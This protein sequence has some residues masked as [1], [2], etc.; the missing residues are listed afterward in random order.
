MKLRSPLNFVVSFVFAALA[1]AGCGAQT[2]LATQWSNPGYGAPPPFKKIVVG[3][4]GGESAVR[5]NFEDEFVAQ[6]RPAGIDAVQSYKYIPEEQNLDEAKLRQVAREA[7]ADGAILAR[8]VGVEQKTE[9]GPS[10]YPYPS[11]GV[12]GPHVGASWYGLFGAPSVRRFEIT[13]SETTLYDVGK[14]EVVWTGT[15]KTTQL[16]DLN[17]VIKEYVAI[18][19]KAL[20]EK[21]LLRSGR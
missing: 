4:S 12:F 16:D 13:T 14:N 2:Q 9:Y 20:N 8:S 10:Y 21:N 11:V 3:G 7:G 18:V 17:S 15:M 6:L 19:I 1:L 5:R